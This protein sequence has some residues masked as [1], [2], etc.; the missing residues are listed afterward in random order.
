[1]FMTYPLDTDSKALCHRSR[2]W[3]IDVNSLLTKSVS[4]EAVAAIL[5]NRPRALDEQSNR[6]PLL[7]RRQTRPL[8]IK[9]SLGFD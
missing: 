9:A 8:I 7:Q 1:M 5:L 2:N 4:A 3:Q 6:F